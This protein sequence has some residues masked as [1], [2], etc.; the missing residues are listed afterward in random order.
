MPTAPDAEKAGIHLVAAP[1]APAGGADTTRRW[2]IAF[3]DGHRR[4]AGVAPHEGEDACAGLAGM[5]PAEWDAVLVEIALPVVMSDGAGPYLLDAGG[6][7]T[8]ALADHPQV[9]G[10]SVAMGEPH[11]GH[12][13]GA[14]RRLPE[15]RLWR[16]LADAVV[17]PAHRVDALDA[18]DRAADLPAL[19]RWQARERM[20]AQVDPR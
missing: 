16:W 20:R 10:A 4:F 15:A 19:E 11:P 14:V 17:A 13:I 7:V 9:P 8:L 2:A 3:P 6:R 18:L 1:D 12:R 5:D